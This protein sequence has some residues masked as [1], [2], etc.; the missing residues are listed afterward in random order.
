M[1]EDLG[2]EIVR[3]ERRVVDPVGTAFGEEE[4][5]MVD[6]FIPPVETVEHRSVDLLFIVDEL[7]WSE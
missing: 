2:I 3:L 5:V 1:A 7:L 4:H 6:F